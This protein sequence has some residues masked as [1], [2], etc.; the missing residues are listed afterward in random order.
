MNLRKFSGGLERI[1]P[2][3]G[4]IGDVD[5]MIYKEVKAEN[6]HSI[7]H[8]GNIF[9]RDGSDNLPNFYILG[10]HYRNVKS[11]GIVIEILKSKGL[12]VTNSVFNENILTFC[13]LIL[14]YY[15][16]LGNDDSTN[17]PVGGIC[18]IMEE[19]FNPLKEINWFTE[20]IKEVKYNFNDY[21]E[22]SRL[23]RKVFSEIQD[24]YSN[25]I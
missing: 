13:P 23:F 2:D 19:P 12:D 21:L 14:M 25:L 11:L 22:T 3:V 5:L 15:N 10:P 6:F 16:N 4:I 8:L 20:H 18:H 9:E 24:N 1:I 7:R 17:Y